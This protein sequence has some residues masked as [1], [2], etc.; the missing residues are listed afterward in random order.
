MLRRRGEIDRKNEVVDRLHFGGVITLSQADDCRKYS[1]TQH[2]CSVLRNRSGASK[3]SLARGLTGFT[4]PVRRG[5]VDSLGEVEALVEAGVV[6][7]RQRDD[8]FARVLVRAENGHTC[9]PNLVSHHE[10]TKNFPSP[11]HTKIRSMLRQELA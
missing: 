4:Y 3:N 2:R 6:R 8:K 11:P 10:Q 5:E 9:R 1:K 7:P